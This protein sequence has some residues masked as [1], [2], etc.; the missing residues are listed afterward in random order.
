MHRNL[1][2]SCLVT[3]FLH[4]FL[5]FFIVKHLRICT[6]E[7]YKGSVTKE[8]LRMLSAALYNTLLNTLNHNRIP[9]SLFRLVRFDAQPGT[10]FTPNIYIRA[11]RV[12]RKVRRIYKFSVKRRIFVL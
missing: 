5:F 8:T 1:M 11:Q 12:K 7:V 3:L 4:N 6:L 10:K 2:M 9:T